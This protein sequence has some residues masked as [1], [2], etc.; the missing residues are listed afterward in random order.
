MSF[1]AKDQIDAET[2]G[3]ATKPDGTS[4]PSTTVSPSQRKVAQVLLDVLETLREGTNDPELPAQTIAVLLHV[5]HSADPPG[6]VELSNLIGMSK[7]SASR[8]V[9]TLGRGLR[10]KGEGMGLVET[11]EAPDNW[12]KKL[13]VLTPKGIA[14]MGQVENKMM[15]GIRRLSL[16]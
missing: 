3:S 6:I 12:S 14:L 13:V 4:S 11:H 16:K 9:Q 10:D 5:A 7:A 8:L 15:T 2:S 1:S